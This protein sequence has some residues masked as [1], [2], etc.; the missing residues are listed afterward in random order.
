MMKGTDPV[1][2]PSHTY[3]FV[4]GQ[5]DSDAVIFAIGGG[6]GGIGKSFI[7]SSLALFLAHMGHETY[8]IDLDLGCANIHTSIGEPLP[9]LGIHDF[10]SDPSLSIKDVSV[11]TAIPNLKLVAGSSD[12]LETADISEFQKSRIMGSLYKLKTKFIV[13]DL[14]AGTHH[15]TLDFFLMATNKIVLFTPEPSSIENAYRFLKAAFYRKVRRLENQL[16]LTE[17]IADLMSRRAEYGLK[18]PGDLLKAIQN[19]D[20][21]AGQKLNRILKDLHLHVILNQVRTLKDTDLGPS[22]KD[23]CV[24]Y[25]GLPFN[26]LGHVEHD[27]AVWQ[28][29]RNRKHLLLEYPHSKVYAQMMNITRNLVAPYLKRDMV[30]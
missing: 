24:K 9:K 14:S 13:L 28:A 23:V 25:F 2:S 19:K 4:R 3:Q 22:I 12:M 5:F 10:L 20:L 27:N 6:K 30:G 7:S 18:S 1:S 8:L 17:M 21:V 29:L 11:P 26:Y 16:E 15:S